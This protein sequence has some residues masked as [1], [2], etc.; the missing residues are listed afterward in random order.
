MHCPK[1]VVAICTYN[2]EHKIDRILN[3]VMKLNYPN[4]HIIVVDNNSNDATQ[5]IVKKY[6]NIELICENKQGLSYA[7]NKAIERCDADVEYL[8]FLD[9]DEEVSTNWIECMLEV[10]DKD[11]KIVAVGGNYIPVYEKE[12][13]KWMPDNFFAYRADFKDIEISNNPTIPGG[14]AMVK[15]REVKRRNIRFATDLGYNGKVLLSGEDVDFFDRLITKKD[16]CGFSGF[17]GVKHYIDRNKLTWKWISKRFFCEG[18][19]QYYRYGFREWWHSVSQLPLKIINLFFT[20]LT[21]D[22]KKIG[23]RFFKLVHCVGVI[24]G[25]IMIR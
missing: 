23:S 24:C 13:P 3:S 4:Y 10:F 18:I 17:A 2:G 15:F 16:L 6:Q 22:S 19:T 14:N 5:S 25:P 11:N 9:D 20:L 12:L 1:V 21:F 8:G 7:R